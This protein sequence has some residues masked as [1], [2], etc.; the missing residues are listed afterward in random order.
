MEN[1]QTLQIEKDLPNKKLTILRQFNADPAIVWRAWTES[2]ILDEWWAPKP[3]KA[4]TKSMDFREGGYWLY[5]MVSPEGERHYARADYLKIEAPKS[6]QLQD[7]FCDESGKQ[8]K[9]MPSMHWTN[10]FSAANNG[11]SVKVVI[12]FDK[13]EDI[14]KIIEMGFEQGFAAGLSNLDEYLAAHA[15]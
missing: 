3:W 10:T 14:T 7:C 8:N 13:E 4:E 1:N 6:F 11:T 15:K 2:D 9:D 12:A 5:A